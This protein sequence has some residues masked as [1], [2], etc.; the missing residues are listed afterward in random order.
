MEKSA[1]RSDAYFSHWKAAFTYMST[2][3]LVSLVFR[4]DMIEK[5]NRVK[6]TDGL[7]K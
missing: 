3:A 1:V 2:A 4:E 5:L 7:P 6:N